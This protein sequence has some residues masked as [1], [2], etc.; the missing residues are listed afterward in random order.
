MALLRD[1]LLP[2]LIGLDA[3]HIEGN[4]R[5]L[6]YGMHALAV[7]PISSLAMAAIDIASWDLGCRR[8]ALPLHKAVGGADDRQPVYTAEVGWLHLDVDQL[9]HDA[10]RMQQ[11]GFKGAKIKIGK[12]RKTE[13][14]ERGQL[15][16][17]YC[18][19][20]IPLQR[21]PVHGIPARR[22]LLGDAGRRARIGGITPWLKVAHLADA[23]NL[24]VSPHFLMELHASLACGIP[25]GQ[26]GTGA[27]L[28][29]G[30]LGAHRLRGWLR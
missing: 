12:L 15:T 16:D 8:A 1:Q 23:Y 4:W 28:G 24:P 7:G 21:Q 3:E 6:L 11:R 22:R 29:S 14:V 27:D 5:S 26:S 13:D 25:N 9:V 19:R 17:S 2:R 20:R 18:H 30:G 10:V